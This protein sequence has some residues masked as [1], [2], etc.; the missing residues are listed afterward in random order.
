MDHL[1]F[2]EQAKAGHTDIVVKLADAPIAAGV[3]GRLD[4]SGPQWLIV[5]LG[6]GDLDAFSRIGQERG[7]FLA[8]T[9]ACLPSGEYVAAAEDDDADCAAILAAAF[10]KFYESTRANQDGDWLRFMRSLWN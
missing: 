10:P 9:L 4:E 7:Y 5:P 1:I 3:L 2:L 6:T 8:G